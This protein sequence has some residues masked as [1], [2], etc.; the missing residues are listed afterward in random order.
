MLRRLFRELQRRVDDNPRDLHARLRLAQTLRA[1]GREHD[2]REELA[3]IA[4]LS[5]AST[6][7]QEIASWAR[8]GLAA[9]DGETLGALLGVPVRP[10]PLQA[11]LARPLTPGEDP[12]DDAEMLE[13]PQEE[14]NDVEEIGDE[15]I[16]GVADLPTL[17][18]HPS[19]RRPRGQSR[20][21]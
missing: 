17:L 20:E 12:F 5:G 11:R 6:K 15:D 18:A 13:G 1:L 3:V 7:P 21:V 9:Q 4:A 10:I 8:A 14:A 19:V 2:A 16:V